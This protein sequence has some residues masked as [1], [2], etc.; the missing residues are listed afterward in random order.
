M[1]LRYA[2]AREVETQLRQFL[3]TD[4]SVYLSSGPSSALR[5]PL[6]SSAMR[7]LA[8]LEYEPESCA[9]WYIIFRQSPKDRS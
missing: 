3:L 1:C 7:G 6:H 5:Q 9:T 8:C 2:V 4:I